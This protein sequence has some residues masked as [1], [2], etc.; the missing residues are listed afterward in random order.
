[1]SDFKLSSIEVTSDGTAA[2]TKV[3]H[4]E[5]GKS[6]GLVQKIVWEV[7][8]DSPWAKAT[9]TVAGVSLKAVIDESHIEINCGQPLFLE[10]DGGIEIKKSEE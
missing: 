8:T 9:I 6:I 7:D 1:M 3:L 5:S 4:K 2:G 10:A